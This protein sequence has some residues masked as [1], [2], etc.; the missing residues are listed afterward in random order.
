MHIGIFSGG[1]DL[2]RLVGEVEEAKAQGFASYAVPQLFGVDALTSLAA[3]GAAV[4]EIGLATA[5]V[6]TYPRHPAALAMQALTVNAVVDGRLVLGIGLS[7]QL[8]IEGMFGIPFE[9]PIRHMREYLEILVPLL[10]GDAVTLEGEQLT[11]RGQ[12]DRVGPPPPVLVAALG[13]Q[14]LALAGRLAAGTATWMTGPKT[15]AEHTIPTI[16]AAAETAG[17]PAP[18]IAAYL[19]VCVTA[20]P[21]KARGQAAE[22]FAIYGELPSYRAM[23]DREGAAGPADVA[24]AGDE[25]SVARVIRSLAEAGVTEFGAVEFGSTEDERRRTRELLRSLL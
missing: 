2:D 23:L 6:P 19:P 21:D 9:A 3:A 20:D 1:N 14:M 5:V 12:L 11:F 17:R 8:V 15:L 25:E 16:T 4:P 7:H 18:R 24:I 10:A 13:S 22:L